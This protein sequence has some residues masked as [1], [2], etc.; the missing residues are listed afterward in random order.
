MGIMMILCYQQKHKPFF[1]I[2]L[3][4]L[5]LL[6]KF[7]SLLSWTLSLLCIPGPLYNFLSFSSFDLPKAEDQFPTTARLLDEF[8]FMS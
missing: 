8:E 2:F 5:F 3:L 1:H 6:S 4:F 7:I